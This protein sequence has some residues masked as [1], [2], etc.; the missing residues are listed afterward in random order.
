MN[1]II[2][3]GNLLV[4]LVVTFC[5]PH[6]EEVSDYRIICLDKADLCGQSVT[7]TSWIIEFPLREKLTSPTVKL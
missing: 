1:I 4:L 7:L 6:A 2:V 3:T 5:V